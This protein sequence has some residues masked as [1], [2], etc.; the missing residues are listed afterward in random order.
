MKDGEL[1]Q[2]DFFALEHHILAGRIR[3]SSG[4]VRSEIHQLTESLQLVG[5]AFGRTLD[6]VQD[7]LYALDNF[8]QFLHAEGPCHSLGRPEEVDGD[9]YVKSLG[10]FE[11]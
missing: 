7:S 9:W 5:D 4:A 2:I 10:V 1:E 11:Q 6:K 8:V 3:D